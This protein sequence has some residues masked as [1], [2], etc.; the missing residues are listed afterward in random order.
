MKEKEFV[1]TTLFGL[2]DLLAKELTEL[3][4]SDVTIRNRAV[5]FNGSQAILYKANLGSRTTMRVLK[6]LKTVRVKDEQSLYDN[7]YKMNWEDH[8]T[9]KNTFMINSSVNSPSFRH[10]LY[11]SQRVKDA[12]ADRFRKITT[13]RPSVNTENPDI[14]INVHISGDRADISLDSSGEPLFKRGYRAAQY[15]APLNEVLAA[16]MLLMTGWNGTTTLIDPMCGTGTLPIEAALIA[17]KIPPGVFRENFGFMKWKDF[18]DLLFKRVLESM[19]D[20]VEISARILASDLSPDAVD[21]AKRSVKKALL[22]DVIELSRQDYRDIDPPEGEGIVIMN[23]PYG[24]RLRED[25]I[26]SFYKQIG[27]TMKQKFQGFDVWILSGN[28]E[29]LKSFGLHSDRKIDLYNGS[30]KCK[31]Q[32]FSIY[33]GSKKQKMQKPLSED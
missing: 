2:E 15:T 23:P 19:L 20:P 31:F 24:E 8:F 28:P 32:K 7:I 18:D 33:S 3:G 4:A 27:D 17:K 11:V 22:D 29:A 5:E 16:G 10:S 9:V 26:N 30:I 1:A 14:T 12:I 13:L 25:E 21:L 6:N